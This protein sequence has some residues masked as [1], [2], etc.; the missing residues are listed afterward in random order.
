MF[1]EKIKR[2]LPNNVEMLKE[3][4]N[5]IKS[6]A[7]VD[8]GKKKEFIK[9]L[10]TD[11]SAQKSYAES[12]IPKVDL[13]L[14][15]NTIASDFFNVGTIG[16]GEPLFYE[17]DYEI[18]A[19]MP[20]YFMSQ[21]GGSVQETFVTDGDVVR[22][23]PY[24]IKAPRVHMNK[25]TLKQGALQGE[26]KLRRRMER[27]MDK[28]IDKD[29][30]SVLRAG[31]SSDLVTDMGIELDEDV[32]NFP[33]TNDIDA[34]AEGGLTLDVFKALADHFNRVG[35]RIRNIY[36]PSNRLSDIYD[37]VSIPAGYDDGSGVS[38]DSVVPSY[39]AEQI[40]KSGQLNG[41]FGYQV[42]LIPTNVLDGTPSGS[43]TEVEMWVSTEAPAGEMRN[44]RDID[45]TFTEQDAD[46]VYFD[47]RKGLCTF[48][49]PYQKMNYARVVFDGQ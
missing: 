4:E 7:S 46:R 6:K 11:G 37:W 38:A 27:N 22:L 34:K 9:S 32:K 29:L 33:S 14:W 18:D 36:V 20:I 13:N 16:L 25:M 42:N 44:V 45:S 28:F 41:V 39:L 40:V 1:N 48:Q 15:A 49:A 2:V 5:L 17:L 21:N 8:S 12:L 26:E 3:S 30:W 43:N 31:L 19:G 47:A 24:L 10:A 35:R 23:H